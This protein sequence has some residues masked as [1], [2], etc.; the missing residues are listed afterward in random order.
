M[1][2]HSILTRSARIISNEPFIELE[3]KSRKKNNDIEENNIEENNIEENNIDQNK[4]NILPKVIKRK[5]KKKNILIKKCSFCRN[6]GHTINHC[7]D[8][9]ITDLHNYIETIAI[10]DIFDNNKNY[11]LSYLNSLD[12]PEIK[13]LCYLH[14]ITYYQ[15]NAAIDK[16]FLYYIK[17]K[18]EIVSDKITNVNNTNMFNFLVELYTEIL[19]ARIEVEDKL[20]SPK[21]VYQKLSFIFYSH[22][23]ERRYFIQSKRVINKNQSFE[24]NNNIEDDCPIC[25]TPLT[26]ENRIITDCNHNYCFGCFGQYLESIKNN[27]N[28]NPKC[29][30]CRNKI[31]KINYFNQN[32]YQNLQNSYLLPDLY[33]KVKN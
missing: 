8:S 24:L 5:P 13:V 6:P 27:V 14:G 31:S 25:F 23:I 11:T 30:F 9:K 2:Q 12:I 26:N 7:N 33:I 17:Y 21:Y 15:I 18:F 10:L 20:F 32:S 29:C 1:L 16:I 28:E 3:F 22:N 19:N 4:E